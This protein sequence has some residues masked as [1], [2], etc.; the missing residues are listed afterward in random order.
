MPGRAALPRAGTADWQELAAGPAPERGFEYDL[1]SMFAR[2]EAAGALTVPILAIVFAVTMLNWANPR[3]ILLWLATI[4]ISEGI[5]LALTRQFKKQPRNAATLTQ[6]RRKLASGEFL[7]G[8]CWA[9]LA[10]ALPPNP[11]QAAYFFLFAAL[12]TVTAIRMLFA[13][14]VMPILHAGTIP[15]T[16]ALCLRFLLTG[17]P[18][19]WLLAVVAAGIHFYFVFLVK[20]LQQTALSMLEHRADK[21]LLIEELKRE[22]EFLRRSPAQGRGRKSREIE[23]PRQYEPRAAHAAQ[24]H[25]GLRRDHEGRD[26]GAHRQCAI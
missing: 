12:M 18:F 23:I 21:D 2:N 25:H 13:A 11:G 6:W 14:S 1:L 15:V 8:V 10:F 7:Y 26:H 3:Q 5:L 4:F 19:Y 20:G 17:E 24:R 22:K 9:A 16:A